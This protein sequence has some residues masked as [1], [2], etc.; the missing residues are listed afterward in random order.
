MTIGF[1]RLWVPFADCGFPQ[2]KAFVDLDDDMI[3]IAFVPSVVCA[4]AITFAMRTLD[5][6]VCKGNEGVRYGLIHCRDYCLRFRHHLRLLFLMHHLDL[7]RRV[8]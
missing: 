3:V 2:E 8:H 6:Y 7:D 1:P 4:F 5:H